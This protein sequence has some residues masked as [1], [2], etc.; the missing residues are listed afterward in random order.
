MRR[1]RKFTGFLLGIF[2]FFVSFN[3]A[4]AAGPGPGEWEE[5]TPGRWE[6]FPERHVGGTDNG[7]SFE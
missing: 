3:G 1:E 4:F 7:I 5:S 6:S 2:L